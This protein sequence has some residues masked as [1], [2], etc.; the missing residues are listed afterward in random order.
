M[1]IELLATSLMLPSVLYVIVHDICNAI[2]TVFSKELVCF[3][4][5]SQLNEV[6]DG[7]KGKWGIIQCAGAIDGSHIPV[8]APAGNHTDY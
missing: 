1:N 7:F 5:G 2:N 3:P 6:I 4:V 8:S